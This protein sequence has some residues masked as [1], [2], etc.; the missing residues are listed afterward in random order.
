M[1]T[2]EASGPWHGPAACMAYLRHAELLPTSRL[3]HAPRVTIIWIF[4]IVKSAQKLSPLACG[5]YLFLHAEE[6]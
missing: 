5:K 2:F 3:F 6:C 1:A 4:L